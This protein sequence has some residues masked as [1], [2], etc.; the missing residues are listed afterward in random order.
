MSKNKVN[1]P[2]A[3]AALDK[4][5]ME[6]ANEVGVPRPSY[7]GCFLLHILLKLAKNQALVFISSISPTNL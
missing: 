5:K 6:A 4:F 1:V 3:R 2:E 7:N